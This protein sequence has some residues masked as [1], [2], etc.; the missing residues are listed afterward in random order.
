MVASAKIREAY[1][2]GRGA[3]LWYLVPTQLQF[4]RY[5][6]L[7]ASEKI[8][9]ACHRGRGA[10]LWYLVPTQLQFSRSGNLVASEKSGRHNTGA[11]GLSCDI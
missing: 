11:V 4:S 5:G 1:H 9:E 6:N 10:V 7:V 8:R 2:R 3:V